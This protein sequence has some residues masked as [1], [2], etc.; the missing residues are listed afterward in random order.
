MDPV[1]VGDIGDVGCRESPSKPE[2]R[3]RIPRIKRFV[4][5]DWDPRDI[6]I[7]IAV[8]RRRAGPVCRWISGAFAVWVL[9]VAIALRAWATNAIRRRGPRAIRSGVASRFSGSGTIVAARSVAVVSA[10]VIVR[11]GF[12]PG[13]EFEESHERG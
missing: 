4:G 1:D 7:W 11:R 8:S 2:P 6:R 12:S 3:A 5:R 9:W 10:A 13:V